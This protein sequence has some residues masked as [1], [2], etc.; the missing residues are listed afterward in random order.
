MRIWNYGVDIM[1][2][3]N[4]SQLKIRISS[5]SFVSFKELV[6]RFNKLTMYFG[7]LKIGDNKTRH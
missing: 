4:D 1:G 7:N 3:L 5:S 2:V 6:K